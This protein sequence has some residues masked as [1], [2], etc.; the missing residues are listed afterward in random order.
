L[1]LTG[2]RVTVDDDSRSLPLAELGPLVGQGNAHMPEAEEVSPGIPHKIF[3]YGA[4]VAL[5]EV[6]LLT[7]EVDLLKIHSVIDAGK[8]INRQGVE[9]QSEGGIVQGLGYA[10]FEDSVVQDGV[11]LNPRL[12]TYI[13]PS[14]S[15]VPIDIQT[16]ILEYP[17]P[18]G[19]YGA[20]G[21]A[22][23]VLTP[24]APAILNAVCAATGVRFT[25]IPL[26]PEEVLGRLSDAD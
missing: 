25:R 7:G 9:A 19:P 17:A 13:I 23:I 10:L 26:T 3:G 24:T 11:M 4:Q 22:E 14:I 20:K 8:V 12:S 2:D 5:V 21:V 15:D 6:D 1:T 16:T 18:E